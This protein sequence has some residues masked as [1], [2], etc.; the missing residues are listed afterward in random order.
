MRVGGSIKNP[1]V[2]QRDA[3]PRVEKKADGKNDQIQAQ[4][5]NITLL[6]PG[7]VV[8]GQRSWS[9]DQRFERAKDL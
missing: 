3:R 4:R 7:Q 5:R 6:A 2:I 9:K 1:Y 8:G